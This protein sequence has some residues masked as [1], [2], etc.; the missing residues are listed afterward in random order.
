[1]KIENAI[2]IVLESVREN[3]VGSDGMLTDNGKEQLQAANVVEDFFVN[4]VWDGTE[5]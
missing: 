5:D 1:M 4:K 2:E 3:T